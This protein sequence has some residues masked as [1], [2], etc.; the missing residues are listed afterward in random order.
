MTDPKWVEMPPS[1]NKTYLLEGDP[2]LLHIVKLNHEDSY[3]IFFYDAYQTEPWQSGIT[4]MTAEEIYIK[5]EI[6]L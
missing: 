5:F 6:T 1:Y 4:V 3:A 2:V